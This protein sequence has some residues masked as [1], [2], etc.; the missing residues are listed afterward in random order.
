MRQEAAW[1]D[2]T[3]LA[4]AAVSVL[5]RLANTGF[6]THILNLDSTAFAQSLKLSNEERLLLGQAAEATFLTKSI[7][8]E[9]GCTA[10]TLRSSEELARVWVD[11]FEERRR[12]EPDD[13]RP[14]DK[15]ETVVPH[16]V[17]L[18]GLIDNVKARAENKLLLQ[19]ADARAA[20]ICVDTRCDS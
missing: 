6:Y 12:W 8:S 17:V 11:L 19:F 9:H 2:A 1:T 15:E 16:A 7:A 18:E 14:I 10:R 4:A 5:D 3:L 20:C 13:R